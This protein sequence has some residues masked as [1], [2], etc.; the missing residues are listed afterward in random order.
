MK[1]QKRAKSTY[2]IVI[3]E[4]NE[5]II[6]KR[7]A[8]FPKYLAIL[9][10][11]DAYCRRRYLSL[12]TTVFAV[13]SCAGGLLFGC[14]LSLSAVGVASHSLPLL[15]SGN[16]LCGVGYG[17]AYT[18]PLQVGCWRNV[19]RHSVSLNYWSSELSTRLNV[20]AL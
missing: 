11:V 12:K 6:I 19:A 7:A 17:C 3:D 2:P 5:I 10:R 14:G 16:M 20:L 8:L 18:P 4:K 15:Y 1:F 13:L 9:F